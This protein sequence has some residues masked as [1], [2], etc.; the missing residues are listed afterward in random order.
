MVHFLLDT[1]FD[2]VA[3]RPKMQKGS[4]KPGQGITVN[5]SI[6]TQPQLKTSFNRQDRGSCSSIA[7][8]PVFLAWQSDPEE[9][10]LPYCSSS[11]SSPT[12]QGSLTNL[13]GPGSILSHKESAVNLKSSVS[14]LQNSL[15]HLKGS[16][17]NLK[18]FPSSPALKSPKLSLCSATTSFHS[19][20]SSFR[21]SSSSLQSGSSSEDDS[22]DTNSW[23]SGATCLLRSSI[24]QHSEEVFRVRAS[25]GSRPKPAS[26]SEA[27]H[28]NLDLQ[29]SESQSESQKTSRKG[30][31]ECKVN[32]Q[33]Q[34]S[35][36]Y[37]TSEHFEEKIEAKLK[38][39]QFL[40]EVT[41]RVLDPE[42]LHAFGLVCQ[43]EASV[44]ILPSSLANFSHSSPLS[45]QQS[46]LG[47]NGDPLPSCWQSKKSNSVPLVTQWKK[48]IPSCK[49]LDPTESPKRAQKETLFMGQQRKKDSVQR[50]DE[51]NS[52]EARVKK[53]E[54]QIEQNTERRTMLVCPNLSQTNF[55]GKK[56]PRAVS[57]KED[58]ILR[59][60]YCSSLPRPVNSNV[61]ST[62]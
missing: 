28:Q 17:S 41:C 32:M 39:S 61:V 51:L 53:K 16:L 20:S 25:S 50:E 8:C 58:S 27:G 31:M 5:G 45:S 10:P 52:T 57:I 42:S 60:S 1:I 6:S 36:H 11:I 40:N 18:G 44:P 24:K 33:S 48:R 3:F 21:S 55:V 54:H 7:S 29:H 15:H 34:N 22:W 14:G 2:G 49:V 38:F 46:T 35:R 4:S 13:H 59:T 9:D 19:S 47:L 26:D 12:L 30:P 37:S 23:N 56:Q 62:I 43:T